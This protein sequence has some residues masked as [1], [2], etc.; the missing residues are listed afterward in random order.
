MNI[1]PQ[2]INENGNN[3]TLSLLHEESLELRR[4][5]QL[6]EKKVKARTAAL[7]R[8][9][10]QLENEVSE[11]VNTEKQLQSRIKFDRILTILASS[12]INLAVHEIDE[13]INDALIDVVA[14]HQCDRAYIYLLVENGR[15]LK[16]SHHWQK[17]NSSTNFSDFNNLPFTL[18]SN[19]LPRLHN[20]ETI[21]VDNIA[22][23]DEEHESERKLLAMQ[24]VKSAVIVPLVYGA[25][26]IGFLGLDTFNTAYKWQKETINKL[27]MVSFIFTNAL[28]RKSTEATLAKERNFAQQIMKSM[29]QGLVVSTVEGTFEYVNP[30]YAQ[31]LGHEPNELIGKTALDVT[32]H[33]D[34]HKLI[35]AQMQNLEGITTSYEARLSRMDGIWLY[36]LVHS[37]P[38][39]DQHGRII[40]TISTVTDLTARR[41]TEAQVEADAEE[42]KLIYEA[43]IQLFQPSS[44]QELAEQIAHI[45]IDQ[46]G[47]DACGV[48]ILDTPLKLSTDRI[49]L[50][51]IEETNH[52]EWLARVGRFCD[53]PL[54]T[55]PLRGEG[56]IA[57]AV[58]KGEIIY[59]PDVTQD[60]RYVPDST[61][62]RSEMVIP[63]R[64]YNHII[65]AIDLQSPHRNG[66]DAQ[67][68]RVITVFAENAGL[69]LETVRLYDKLRHHAQELEQQICERQKIENALRNSEQRY[70]HL[71]EDA[72]DII[73]RTDASGY[74]TYANPITIRTLGYSSEDE[75]IGRHY[76]DFIHPDYKMM[77]V[78]AY[79]KQQQE[80]IENTYFEFLALGN[81]Q[82]EIWLGQ[83]VQLIIE[84]GEVIGFQAL[85][86]DITKRRN[87]EQELRARSNELNASNAKLAKAV[88]TKDEFLANMSH[89]LRTPLNAILGKS[90]ILL[91][92][93]HGSLN[94]KQMASL[95]VIGDSGNH[96]L[97]LI[98]DIL[99][100][101]KIEA[102]KI[103]PDIRKVSVTTIVETSLQFVRQMALKKQ[104]R[105]QANI[106][107][108]LQMCQTDER[109]LK[110]IL[111][112]LLSNA[113][114]FTPVEGEVG[115]N[116]VPDDEH[117]TIQFQVW[118]TGIGIPAE[119]MAQLFKPFVQLDSSL[120]RSHEGTGL[121]L[122]LV[123]RL[124]KMLGGSVSLESQVGVGSCFTIT[125]P[126]NPNI[127]SEQLHKQAQTDR[128]KFSTAPLN[129]KVADK[130]PLILLVEDNE[131]NIEIVTEYLPVWGYQILVAHSGVEALERAK[132]VMPDLILMDVQIPELDGLTAVR[133]L[134]REETFRE[135]P[136][137]ALTALAMNGDRERC[138]EAGANEYMSKPIQLRQLALVINDLLTHKHKT[139]KEPSYE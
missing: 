98:N 135:T 49:Q 90:E 70:K 127:D 30:A 19:W 45:T 78:K 120:V 93:I 24:N 63:L 27:K 82:E 113:V 66:F 105:L 106:D 65:G 114:K 56:L 124:T 4:T 29:G 121:G 40:G 44:V 62:T 83:N 117:E 61:Y 130:E 86:R 32:Y 75:L 91:E 126:Q 139:T 131:A 60:A 7:K 23:L 11:R 89:E 54:G 132:Q 46:L 69:A 122:S 119:D 129:N 5:N 12:F 38:N 21:I 104:V 101:A 9:N 77:L 94:E 43:A 112:N 41:N 81:N 3:S 33:E 79:N 110:Q 42:V 1:Q 136:I 95:Q 6:L 137:V 10:E 99:D 14:F 97:E 16:T 100:M 67:A 36:A 35:Q 87:T 28:A 68:R 59:V 88:R 64:A 109:R 84:Q 50:Y 55:I 92:G 102:G 128:Q 118:D 37:V 134:R 25:E 76:T 74:C 47:F 123:Y 111:I 103:Q 138:L 51:P 22:S 71:V 72:T 80:K 73:Y 8:T 17:P 57:T 34:R 31:M 13:G 18:F 20:Q 2:Q 53:E 85:A 26:T 48:L 52:L 133:Q 116:V 115:L 108:G 15:A 39:L 107:H 125:L 96:L 58:R